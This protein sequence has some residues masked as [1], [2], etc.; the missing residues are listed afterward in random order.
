MPEFVP[1]GYL[2]IRR[3]HKPNRPR[4]FPSEWGGDEHKARPGL[5]SAEEWLRIKD[6]PPARGGGAPGGAP[7]R[8][9]VP[10]ENS[11][12]HPTSNPS[13]PS[14]QKECRAR[15]RCVGARHRLRQL[16]GTGDLEAAILDPF[17][18]ALHRASASLWRRHDADRMIEKG[19]HPIPHNPNTGS[20]G[21]AIRRGEWGPKPIP[22]KN[23]RSNRS[24][25]EKNSNGKS[26]TAATKGFS[27]PDFSELPYN[28]A[29]IKRDISE[30]PF[31]RDGAESPTSKSNE[32]VRHKNCYIFCWLRAIYIPRRW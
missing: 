1:N 20:P 14:Y 31:Q 11:E 23:S 25:E 28:R 5:I 6:L 7:I 22:S 18:G 10:A 27:A 19:R 9:N 15:Q 4:T 8:A 3:S 30:F 29:S 21:Q 24:I 17:T 12:P 26:D 16:L 2:S 32:I 13:D